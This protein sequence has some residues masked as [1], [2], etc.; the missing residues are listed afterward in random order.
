MWLDEWK[1]ETAVMH[2]HV[3]PA[4]TRIAALKPMLYA[5]VDGSPPAHTRI[6]IQG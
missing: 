2:V 3:P 4:H 5:A 1:R 6:A